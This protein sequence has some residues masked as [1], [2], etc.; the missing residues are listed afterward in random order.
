[1]EI[2]RPELP[3]NDINYEPSLTVDSEPDIVDP[4]SAQTN[5][6]RQQQSNNNNPPAN[7]A[8]NSIVE[9]SIVTENS[10]IAPP[11]D[12]RL[13]G[14]QGN[15]NNNRLDE[16]DTNIGSID[17]GD[18]IS[19]FSDQPQIG[20]PRSNKN[21][22]QW[23]QQAGNNARHRN[24]YYRYSTQHHN[25]NR[26]SNQFSAPQQPPTILDEE[27][28]FIE[29]SNM[30]R[31]DNAMPNVVDDEYSPSATMPIQGARS[32]YYPYSTR[33]SIQQQY[34]HKYPPQISDQFRL[35]NQNRANQVSLSSR[36]QPNDILMK[37]MVNLD[38]GVDDI[39]INSPTAY[40][41][42]TDQQQQTNNYG[43]IYNEDSF[44]QIHSPRNRVIQSSQRGRQNQLQQ[45]NNVDRFRGYNNNN[46]NRPIVEEAPA[47]RNL[48]SCGDCQSSTR[49]LGS[50][51]FCHSE[52]A[53]KA[54]ILNKFMAEDW[55][56]FDVEIQDIFKSP[57][58]DYLN[59]NIV[60]GGPTNY[61]VDNMLQADEGIID[62]AL[63]V[64]NN[65]QPIERQ[66]TQQQQQSSMG[67][68]GLNHKIKVGTIQ[69]I[70]V[71]TEDLT[72]KCPKLKLRAT[73][74]LMGKSINTRPT[75][76]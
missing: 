63:Q 2:F 57:S 28:E 45:S 25:Q 64:N 61:V 3:E 7:N 12:G 40:D 33:Q 75:H 24:N 35:N 37:P 43:Q 20:R 38:H 17:D 69:S 67:Q 16:Q 32:A 70:W 19:D 66:Q 58:L 4:S 23:N 42:L 72:C 9:P 10:N 21:Y 41:D 48:V 31:V 13:N 76:S 52:F 36:I 53:I 46:N 34:K 54:T 49:R 39:N 27:D 1:M 71:P 73:Y 62:R 65:T 26:H 30:R 5:E 15:N 11:I 47:A 60:V 44:N 74:L 68:L 6:Q 51:Q 50:K 29:T 55:T 56:R 8:A 22:Q 14:R 59:R 18:N